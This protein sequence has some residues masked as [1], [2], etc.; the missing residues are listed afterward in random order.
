[1]GIEYCVDR[2]RLQT[3]DIRKF[4]VC[5]TKVSGT[6]LKLLTVTLEKAMDRAW[7]F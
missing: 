5:R 3:F 6:S 4:N 2:F 1:M 7:V